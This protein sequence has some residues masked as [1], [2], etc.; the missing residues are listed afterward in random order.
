[1]DKFIIAF[2][3]LPRIPSIVQQLFSSS[4]LCHKIALAGHVNVVLQ[5]RQSLRHSFAHFSFDIAGCVSKRVAS[6]GWYDSIGALCTLSWRQ[7][8]FALPP[9]RCKL[10]TECS[11]PKK[12][13]RFEDA[14]LQVGCLKRE[15][16]TCSLVGRPLTN[17]RLCRNGFCRRTIHST[18]MAAA[19]GL[20]STIGRLSAQGPLVL[21]FFP[22]VMVVLPLTRS[23]PSP[24]CPFRPL[25]ASC[26][27]RRY[28][29]R[30]FEDKI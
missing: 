10:R 6:L 7:H 19:R 8:I 11:A 16:T 12:I 17:M 20:T 13:P 30:C 1:M 24:F 21:F 9:C 3:N 18:Q 14:I 25:L 4:V 15:P 26:R 28:V 2:L 23:P 22:E 5:G 27:P 29:Q